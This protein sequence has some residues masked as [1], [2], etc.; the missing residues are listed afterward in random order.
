[1][2]TPPSPLLTPDLLLLILPH[3][4]PRTLL[5]SQRVCRLW[6]MTIQTT[7][8]LQEALFF[9]PVDTTQLQPQ[10]SL[11]TPNTTTT[12]TT[13]SETHLTL[14]P[15]LQTTF[16]SFFP[17]STSTS[18]STPNP[19]NAILP[20][21]QNPPSLRPEASWRRM[22]PCQPPSRSIGI[23]RLGND[24]GGRR[25]TR[26]RVPAY[27][28]LISLDEF[29]RRQ[30]SDSETQDTERGMEPLSPNEDGGGLRMGLLIDLVLFDHRYFPSRILTGARII[31]GK[32]LPVD[33]EEKYGP[34]L[35][36]VFARASRDAYVVLFSPVD[37]GAC[38]GVPMGM[39]ERGGSGLVRRGKRDV[40]AEVE[41]EY[42]RLG[43]VGREPGVEGGIRAVEWGELPHYLGPGFRA[44]SE[45]RMR[46][47]V[48]DMGEVP[49]GGSRRRRMRIMEGEGEGE[50]ELGGFGYIDPELALDTHHSTHT[51]LELW[52]LGID[53][54]GGPQPRPGEWDVKDK[55][56]DGDSQDWEYLPQREAPT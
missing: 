53:A 28:T 16:P 29:L 45:A 41:E 49:R 47:L 35:G 8:S 17:S 24:I 9:L 27:P 32:T 26:Y 25:F 50:G 39:G 22:L 14:N 52:A 56:M 4:D 30:E 2:T 43:M 7:R 6:A 18:T 23:I 36:E 55:R 15:L 54:E 51:D 40:R 12:K 11:T 20:T 46:E 34:R 44:W 10:P 31:W 1:M 21:L 5:T 48:R 3:L 33:M 42:R 13:R 38:V 37:V 19:L